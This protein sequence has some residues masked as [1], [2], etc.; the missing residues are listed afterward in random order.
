MEHK[1]KICIYAICK[2]ES[3][4]VEQWLDSMSEADYI[5]VLDTGSTDDTFE[6]LK[7]DPRVTRV[8]QKVITPWR[9]DVARNESLKL[10]PEDANILFCTDLDELLDPGW[11]EPLRNEWNPELHK[12]GYYT[13]AWSHTQE[14]APAT[15]FYYDKIHN[16]EWV[17][18]HPVHEMLVLKDETH[19]LVNE[20]TIFFGDRIY[21][22][23]WPDPTKSRASYLGLLEL[24]KEEDP[25]DYYGKIYLAHEYYYRGY[26]QKSIDE[27][28]DILNNYSDKYNEIEKASCYLFMG[29]SY[30]KLEQYEACIDAYQK[31]IFINNT[32]REPY[33]RLAEVFNELQ[34]YYQ[35]IGAIKEC[36]SKSYRHY[37]WLERGD[38]WTYAPYDVLAIAYYYTGD[39]DKSYTNAKKALYYEPNDERLLYNLTFIENKLFDN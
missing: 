16:N 22:H 23:H 2:N 15:V 21:L 1:N 25:E 8:E 3:Q 34:Y 28:N 10:V 39:Y 26:Y 14:G 27:L 20:E 31:A 33:I 37:S 36:L 17:W 5:V 6:K 9:F 11:A 4:F 38:S 35:A 29:D 24:R 12:R 18:K 13:Y 7:A 19:E 30:R 32:Y